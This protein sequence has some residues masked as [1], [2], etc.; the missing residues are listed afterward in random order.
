[1]GFV[2]APPGASRCYMHSRGRGETSWHPVFPLLFICR[3]DFMRFTVGSLSS[4][5][6]VSAAL[7][8]LSCML[9]FAAT[10]W[11]VL[12]TFSE[13][14]A[15]SDASAHLLLIEQAFQAQTIRLT[16]EVSQV[17]RDPAIE[18]ALTPSSS[19]PND[20]ANIVL[21]HALTPYRFSALALIS[22]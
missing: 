14:Q 2:C 17:A 6:I 11:Y 21:L 12:K 3:R 8:L 18:K 15:R 9:L 7:T 20:Q 1:M 19:T 10:S 22:P 4:K 16:Q 5:L 13:N